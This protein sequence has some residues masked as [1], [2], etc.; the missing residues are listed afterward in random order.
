MNERLTIRLGETLSRALEEEARPT[1]LPKARVV[2]EA[3]QSRLR[4]IAKLKIMSRYFGMIHGPGD[5]SS[6]KSYRRKQFSR[7]PR[8]Q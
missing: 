2:R 6:N 4:P 3:L 7:R 1:G 5:L 8:P